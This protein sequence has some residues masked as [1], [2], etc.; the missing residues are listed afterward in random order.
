[1]FFPAKELLANYA[2]DHCAIIGASCPFQIGDGDVLGEIK[3]VRN[4]LLSPQV[5]HRRD[6]NLR[7]CLIDCCVELFCIIRKQVFGGK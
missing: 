6:C 7:H 5:R 2:S 4:L 1:L 3:G